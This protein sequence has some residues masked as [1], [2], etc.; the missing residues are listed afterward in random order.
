M[1]L[2]CLQIPTEEYNRVMRH[3]MA[4]VEFRCHVC[5]HNISVTL[6]VFIVLLCLCLVLVP[7]VERQLMSSLLTGHYQQRQERRRQSEDIELVHAVIVW[8]CL[9]FV[10][11][12]VVHV[13]RKQVCSST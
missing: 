2:R 3:L 1:Y 4:D 7:P 11:F 12:V 13:A 8:L 9:V 6:M 10:Y 5:C